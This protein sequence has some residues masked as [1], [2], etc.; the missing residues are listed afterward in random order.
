MQVR[1]DQLTWPDVEKY[2]QQ[3][4]RAIITI[5]A[6][7]QHGPHLAMGTDSITAEAVAFDAAKE[8]GVLVYPPIW[9]GWSEIHM[10]FE[11]TISLRAK[12]MQLV[13]EDLIKSL[14][15]HGF[16]RFI[17]LNGNRR[18]NL[19]PLQVAAS[20]LSRKGDKI[21][22]IAD[23]AYLAFKECAEIRR[24]ELGG[25][26]HAGEIETSHILHINSDLVNMDLAE[27][28][29]GKVTSPQS[30]FLSSDPAH[31]GDNRYYYSKTSSQFRLNH[32]NG[33]AGDPTIANKETGKLV[34]EAMVVGLVKLLDIIKKTKLITKAKR[35]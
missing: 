28:S 33:V 30:S 35:K 13:I 25:I 10:D 19:P 20:N 29:L 3:D 8:S 34:H 31:E 17:V 7:E 23:V 2:L 12:T 5:G 6:V 24:S 21:V 26:G 32:P 14:S 18:A 15:R 16:K 1:V 27:K 22:F 4:D 11:G 9:Y